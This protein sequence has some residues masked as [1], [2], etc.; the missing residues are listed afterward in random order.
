MPQECFDAMGIGLFTESSIP[1]P[2][3]RQYVRAEVLGDQ[4]VVRGVPPSN[5]W[6]K[7]LGNSM[8]PDAFGPAIA[9]FLGSLKRLN[10]DELDE[11][12]SVL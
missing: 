8:S 11:L 3:S 7:L 12:A 1:F 4:Q 5:V 10:H 2:W 9:F 6:W